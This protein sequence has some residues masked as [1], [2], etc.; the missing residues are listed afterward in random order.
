[1]CP[2]HGLEYTVS[3]GDAVVVTITHDVGAPFSDEHYQVYRDGETT[4]FQ[5]GR[6]DALGRVVFVPDRTGTW[7][8]RAF[9]EDGHGIDVTIEHSGD[10]PASGGGSAPRRWSRL[11][12]GLSLIFGLFG[13]IALF[14]RRTR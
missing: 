12:V 10:A 11:V 9:S 13:V 1:M 6:T 14:A 3:A 2:A 7:I 8:V 5:T 4:A